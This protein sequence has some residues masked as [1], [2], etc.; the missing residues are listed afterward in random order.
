MKI[1][2]W[3][4]FRT[5]NETAL[6]DA[7]R[8]LGADVVVCY[9]RHYDRYRKRI[10]WKEASLAPHE[11]FARTVGEARR[12][13]TD[14]SERIQVVPSFADRIS[15]RLIWWCVL[16][17][18]PWFASVER[19]RGRL[20]TW[21]LRKL[22][23]LAV[24]RWALLLF[25]VG[26]EAMRQYAAL[27]VREQKLVWTTYAMPPVDKD[28]AAARAKD[29]VSGT[30]AERLVRFAFVG[31]LTHRKAADVLCKAFAAVRAS[32]PNV[33]LKLVGDGPM[34]GL[35]E[36]VDG[37]R[38]VG[39][40]SPDAVDRELADCDA[41]VLPSRYDAWGV[42]LVEGARMGLA[43][44]AGDGVGA[45]E[46]VSSNPQNGFVVESG[47]VDALAAAMAFYAEH[48]QLAREH[49]ANARRAAAATDAS[50][51]AGNVLDAISAAIAP[52]GV[53]P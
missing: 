48:P 40:L 6:V 41:I 10:G 11:Y 26:R 24:N 28:A 7:M 23:A 34:R 18:Q 20:A 32:H 14:F 2:W 29:E 47:R 13:I 35:F 45:S 3:T 53:F 16:H 44:I 1:C 36:G 21:P 12:Q 51:L 38:L 8:S 50:C 25:C 52:K 4:D 22:F 39:A 43:M 5:A 31:A 42:A 30:S 37:A 9:F 46:L 19:S 49:G 17:K 33:E 27:G 15:W